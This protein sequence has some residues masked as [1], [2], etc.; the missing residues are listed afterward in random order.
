M[1]RDFEQ[2]QDGCCS[3]VWVEVV[4]EGDFAAP[5]KDDWGTVVHLKLPRRK[6]LAPGVGVELSTGP[7]EEVVGAG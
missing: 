4:V 6:G 1:V 7:G 3:E 2:E 5:R